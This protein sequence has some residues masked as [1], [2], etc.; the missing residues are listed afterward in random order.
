MTSSAGGV[1]EQNAKFIFSFFRYFSD[2]SWKVIMRK[3]IAEALF[4]FFGEKTSSIDVIFLSH[5]QCKGKG[6]K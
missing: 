6:L 4:V 3:N 1:W 5:K 2:L